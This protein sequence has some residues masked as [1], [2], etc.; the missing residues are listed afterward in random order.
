MLDPRRAADVLPPWCTCRPPGH[1]RGI[2]RCSDRDVAMVLS[3]GEDGDVVMVVVA[4]EVPR[5]AVGNAAA[6]AAALA[7]LGLPEWMGIDEVRTDRSGLHPPLPDV[8]GWQAFCNLHR[9]ESEHSHRWGDVVT[10]AREHARK[11]EE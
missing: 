9:R 3:N 7:A 11:H 10:D 2:A 4:D 1:G 6:M 8:Y 5:P